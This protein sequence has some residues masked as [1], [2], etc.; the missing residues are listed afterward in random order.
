MVALIGM[1]SSS[2]VAEPFE[3]PTRVMRCTP[4]ATD[5]TPI[6]TLEIF[7]V[8]HSDLGLLV[9]TTSSLTIKTTSFAHLTVSHDDRN[10]DARY[11]QALEL[12]GVSEV[13]V[14]FNLVARVGHNQN[15]TLWRSSRDR[16]VQDVRLVC[17]SEPMLATR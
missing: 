4:M 5:Q 17:D 15:A 7:R 6:H 12:I 13:H 3:T 14:G 10:Q 16:R 1:V 2:A 9:V 11:L 8:G